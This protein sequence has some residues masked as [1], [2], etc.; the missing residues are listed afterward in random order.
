VKDR[1]HLVDLMGSIRKL[2][3]VFTVDRVRGSYFGNVR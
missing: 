1:T 3:G 2:K